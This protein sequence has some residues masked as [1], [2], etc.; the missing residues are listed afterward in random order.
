MAGLGSQQA[1]PLPSTTPLPSSTS[2]PTSTPSVNGTS[3]ALVGPLIL[4]NPGVVRQGTSFNVMGSGF[5]AKATIDLVL[6]R[7]ATG[8]TLASTFVQTH[9][10]G[11]FLDVTLTVPN[12]LPSATFHGLA[13]ARTPTHLA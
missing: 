4:L 1:T 12:A 13:P 5:D 6:K 8:S 3:T 7:Q 10:G 9:K 11:T 2:L